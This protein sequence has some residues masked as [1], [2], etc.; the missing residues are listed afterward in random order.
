MFRPVH[1]NCCLSHLSPGQRTLA[2]DTRSSHSYATYYTDTNGDGVLETIVPDAPSEP[3]QGDALYLREFYT[4][5]R[6][7]AQA[8]EQGLEGT[9]ILRISVDEQGVVQDVQIHQSASADLDKAA[10]DAYR[11][12]SR[13]GY[14]PLLLDGVAIAYKMDMQV[15]FSLE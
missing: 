7:P 13:K 15:T 14:K 6:Y 5:L 11:H 9:V 12:A 4:N 1:F 10:S 2:Q 3:M 8:R